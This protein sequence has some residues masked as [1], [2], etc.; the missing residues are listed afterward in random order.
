[1]IFTRRQFVVGGLAA[2]GASAVHVGLRAQSPVRPRIKPPRLRAGDRIGLVNPVPVA[3]DEADVRGAVQALESVGLSPVRGRSVHA[4]EVPSERERADEI[5]EMFAD[6]RVHGIIAL[7][8]GWGCAGLLP[9]LDYGAISAHPKIVL[10]FS[11]VDALVLGIHA[12]TGLVTFHGPTGIA[13]WAP[14]TVA[15]MRRLLFDAE[16]PALAA[17]EDGA[18]VVSGQA[19]GRL[20][21]GNL[22]VVSS[23]VGSPYLGGEDEIVLFLE[24]V[25]EPFSEVDRMLTQ[26]RLA[27]LLDRATAVVFGRCAWCGPPALDR[28]LTLGRVLVDQLGNRGVPVF[29]GVPFGHVAAQLLVPVGISAHVDAERRIVRLLEPAVA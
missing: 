3:P 6:P 15:Q 1:V 18:T 4:G 25:S 16:R 20:L 7:R 29:L 2:M 13:P 26:L 8:G 5:N 17:A 27:G 14:D 9:H 21:G 19:H 23:L 10:G 22:T 28:T 11:D 12:M 24:E